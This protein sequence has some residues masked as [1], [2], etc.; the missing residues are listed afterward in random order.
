MTPT[1]LLIDGRWVDGESTAPVLDKFRGLVV[2]EI[3]QASPGQVDEAVAAACAVAASGS[4][5]PHARHEV[6]IGAAQLLELRRPELVAGMVAEAGFTVADAS[7]EVDRAV[8]TL[9]L[10]G[11]EA[12]RIH[13]EVVP[14]SSA[15]GVT[16]RL[17]FTVR[18]PVGVVVAITPFNSPLNT[19]AHK[20]GPALAAGNAVVLKPAELTPLTAGTLAGALVDAGLPP[21]WLNVVHGAGETV[22]QQLLEHPE[23]DFYTFTGSTEVG[24]TIQRS[25]GL[26]RTQL[27]LGSLSCTIVCQD[28]DPE[29]VAIRAVPAS[30]RKAGQVCTS[31]QR[32]YVHRDV[33]DACLAAMVAE[34]GSW[35]AGDPA[36]ERTRVG[37]L[38]TEAAAARVDRWVEAAADGGARVVLGGG[39]T[40]SVVTPTV[41]TDVPAASDLWCRELFGPVVSVVPY[42]DLGAT[43]AE[44]DSLPYGLAAGVFTNDIDRALRVATTL[45]VG[46]VHVND[47]S[48][49]RVDQVPYGGMKASGFGKEGPK[50]A[51][52]EMTEETL[53]T[54][55]TPTDERPSAASPARRPAP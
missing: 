47:T 31:V 8:Q 50:Y 20:V 44:I 45:R 9:T 43:L 23:P 55:T 52:A 32:L 27:E 37:P 39:R 33:L 26:R 13:G 29:R 42:D 11:E 21:G 28:A 38:I 46:S 54:I 12:T 22:G 35:P 2:A 17:A 41:V 15:P 53:V 30:F 18:R 1:L 40:G 14:I 7:V 49:S 3:A 36:D 51:A 34:A 6:L 4:L 25:V 24:R 5:H 19:V 16:G 10:S 48:S